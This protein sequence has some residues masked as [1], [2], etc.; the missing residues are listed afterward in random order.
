MANQLS[1]ELLAQLFAQES[2]DPFLILLTLSHDSFGQ[3][4][5][6]NNSENITSR[7]QVF[8]AYPMNIRLP[9]DDGETARNFVIEFDNV[10]LELIE[11]IRTVTD[12]IGVKLEMILA[13]IPDEVQM[14]QD[15]LTIQSL[16]YNLYKITAQ[17]ILDNFLGTEMTSERYGPTNFPGLF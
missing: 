8:Q 3:I 4:R 6:V 16:G 5:L 1:P 17:V 7:G 12:D 11:E 14:V 9:V 15:E 2:N 13:S 10:A